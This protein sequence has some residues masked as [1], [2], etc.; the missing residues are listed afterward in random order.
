[1][2]DQIEMDVKPVAKDEAV[3][4]RHQGGARME[5]TLEG[6]GKTLD[7]VTLKFTLAGIRDLQINTTKTR[8]AGEFIDRK[9]RCWFVDDY[10]LERLRHSASAEKQRREKRR[11]EEKRRKGKVVTV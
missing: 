3:E 8:K 2:G 5:A 1:M 7:V 4:V 10:T 9:M 11:A 6:F